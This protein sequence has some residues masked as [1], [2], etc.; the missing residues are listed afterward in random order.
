MGTTEHK[1]CPSG[2]PRVD[3]VLGGLGAARV[4]Q[5][6]LSGGQEVKGCNQ[7]LGYLVRRAGKEFQ[8]YRVQDW[9]LPSAHGQPRVLPR[10]YRAPP[11]QETL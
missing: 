11:I 10:S 2:G 6:Y 9:A 7:H 1:E 4:H 3:Q 5:G 8:P